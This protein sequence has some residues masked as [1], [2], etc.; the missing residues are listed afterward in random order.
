VPEE[1]D[2]VEPL[3]SLAD[4]LKALTVVQRFVEHQEDATADDTALL[5]KIERQFNLRAS[6]ACKQSSLDR[7]ITSAGGTS[8]GA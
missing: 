2:V 4:A 1:D 8:E 3:P 6:K 5:H 7:W